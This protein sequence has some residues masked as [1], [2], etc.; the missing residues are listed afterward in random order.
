MEL[1]SFIDVYMNWGVYIVL[2]VAAILFFI[3][4]TLKKWMH[5][6]H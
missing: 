5:G 3:S 2:G 4:P 6:V 1:Q